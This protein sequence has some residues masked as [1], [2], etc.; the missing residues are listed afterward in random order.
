MVFPTKQPVNLASASIYEEI[1]RE[2]AINIANADSRPHRKSGSFF[3]RFA[4]K[5]LRFMD[6]GR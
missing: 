2:L 4:K 1:G 5:K 6:T 3:R